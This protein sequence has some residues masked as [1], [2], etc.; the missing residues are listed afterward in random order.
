MQSTNSCV[1]FVWFQKHLDQDQSYATLSQPHP[2]NRN[3]D[4]LWPDAGLSVYPSVC[5]FLCQV[6]P[7][8]VCPTRRTPYNTTHTHQHDIGTFRTLKE[9][10]NKLIKFHYL[11]MNYVSFAAHLLMWKCLKR[12]DGSSLNRKLLY[13]AGL[14]GTDRCVC[15]YDAKVVIV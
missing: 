9:A 14:T 7:R 5:L 1:W 15:S 10:Q 11:F 6:S 13:T 2:L 12:T 4:R 3:P 8:T